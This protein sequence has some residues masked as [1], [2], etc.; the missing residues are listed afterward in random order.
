VQRTARAQAGALWGDLDRETQAF[1]LAVPGGQIS[2]TGIAGLTLGGGVGWLSRRYGLTIDSLL[3][4]DLVTADGR[5]VTA[6]QSEHPDLSWGLRGGSGN[7]GVAVSFEYRLH[8]VGPLVLGGPVLYPLGDAAAAL[9][10]ARAAMADAPDEVSLWLSLTHIPPH[11]P[12]YGG[13]AKLERLRELKREW[14]P[15]NLFRLNPNIEP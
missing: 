7:F 8:E 1:G 15:S 9:R 10:N 13:H 4:V 14:D 3:S 6:S 12:A 2:H 11:P 5:L